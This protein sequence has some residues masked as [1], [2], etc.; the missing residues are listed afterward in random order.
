MDKKLL[1]LLA[2]LQA[3]IDDVSFRIKQ[4][5]SEKIV[6]ELHQPMLELQRHVTEKGRWKI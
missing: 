5:E 2:L 4:G 6:W 3:K 1:E